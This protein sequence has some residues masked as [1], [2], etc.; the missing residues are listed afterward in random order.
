MTGQ[1]GVEPPLSPDAVALGVLVQEEQRR[2]PRP[3]QLRDRVEEEVHH[4]LDVEVGSEELAEFLEG[5]GQIRAVGS[6]VDGG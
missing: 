1:G 5:G 4:S 2:S 3:D 6:A